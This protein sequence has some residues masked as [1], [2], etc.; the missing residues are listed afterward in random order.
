MTSTSAARRLL[1]SFASRAAVIAAL[2]AIAIPALAATGAVPV[3]VAETPV[4]VLVTATSTTPQ[5]YFNVLYT[6]PAGKMLIVDSMTLVSTLASQS[7][8]LGA[9]VLN[10]DASSNLVSLVTVSAPA[11]TPAASTQPMHLHV[12]AGNT[13]LANVFSTSGTIGAYVSFSG[14]LVDTP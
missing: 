9:V 13:L 3:V 8:P 1:R 7:T 5:S 11:G 4:E 14:H 6:V 12:A 2:G 10:R